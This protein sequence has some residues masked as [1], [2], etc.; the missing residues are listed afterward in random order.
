MICI[1]GVVIVFEHTAAALDAAAVI[2]GHLRWQTNK[3][4]VRVAARSH[5]RSLRLSDQ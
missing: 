3:S 5:I 4:Q 2:H 1:N